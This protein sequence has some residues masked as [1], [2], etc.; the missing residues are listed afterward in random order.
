MFVSNKRH[1]KRVD[2]DGRVQSVEYFQSQEHVQ[3]EKPI[4]I[5]LENISLGGIG[6]KSTEPLKV[7]M[8][9][10]LNLFINEKNYSVVAKVVWTEDMGSYHKSGLELLYIPD[11][12]I[13]EIREIM[14]V[15]T[16]YEN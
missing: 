10:S 9:I 6:I 3:I 1:F 13:E 15:E 12:L 8:T 14:N 11:E 2:N 16:R 7:D 5:S 4:E